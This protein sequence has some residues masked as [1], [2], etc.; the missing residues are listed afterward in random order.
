MNTEKWAE[1][2]QDV[3]KTM[4]ETGKKYGQIT[5]AAAKGWEAKFLGEL[6]K[7]GA[8]VKVMPAAER[9]KIK[10]ISKSVWMKWAEDNGPDAKR[11]L[12]L[13]TGMK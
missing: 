7:E 12:E 8:V 2:P 5:L 11:L 9:D 3:K 6:N 4:I 13:V 10:E 1:L